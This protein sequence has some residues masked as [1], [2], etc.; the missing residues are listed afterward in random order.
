MV[1]ICRAWCSPAHRQARREWC[2]HKTPLRGV[3]CHFAWSC[4]MILGPTSLKRQAAPQPRT[5][6]VFRIHLSQP[7]MT[8]RRGSLLETN[9]RSILGAGRA[10]VSCLASLMRLSV[11]WL[12]LHLVLCAVFS[13]C[14]GGAFVDLPRLS[15]PRGRCDSLGLCWVPAE[16][17]EN[18]YAWYA[19]YPLPFVT[20]RTKCAYPL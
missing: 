3:A 11:G 8:A 13:L 6:S 12:E 17:L 5:L 9:L 1:N 19:W 20:C 10:G 2:Y 4:V 16:L 15:A 18:L 7:D 14:F